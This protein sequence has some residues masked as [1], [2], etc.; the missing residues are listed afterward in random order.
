MCVFVTCFAC[1]MVFCCELGIDSSSMGLLL[2]RLHIASYL[3]RVSYKAFI[4]GQVASWSL[5]TRGFVLTEAQES[6]KETEEAD[7]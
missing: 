1:L 2:D 3:Q 5:E 6:Y 7:Y 4:E